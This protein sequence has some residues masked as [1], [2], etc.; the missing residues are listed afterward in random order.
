MSIDARHAMPGDL[1]NNDTK[2]HGRDVPAILSLDVTTTNALPDTDIPLL[3]CE[4]CAR[5]TFNALGFVLMSAT[6]E[7]L[8]ALVG[9]TK[10]KKR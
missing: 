8:K 2:S 4:Q 3:L 1:C 5:N 10:V 9:L 6:G 7:S